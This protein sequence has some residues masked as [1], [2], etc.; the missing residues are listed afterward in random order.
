MFIESTGATVIGSPF[1]STLATPS[2]TVTQD[3][4]TLP[5]LNLGTGA[6]S[7]S[8]GAEVASASCTAGVSVSATLNGNTL[9]YTAASQ[10]YVT[11]VGQSVTVGAGT[12]VSFSDCTAQLLSGQTVDFGSTLKATSAS[13]VTIRLSGGGVLYI[14]DGDILFSGETTVTFSENAYA[15]RV[16]AGAAYN[17]ATGG[18]AVS[19]GQTIAVVGPVTGA[20]ISTYVPGVDVIVL[21]SGRIV[22]ASTGQLVA[23]ILPDGGVIVV[24]PLPPIPDSCRSGA[25]VVLPARGGYSRAVEACTTFDGTPVDVTAAN[26]GAVTDLVVACGG[27]GKHAF[28][29]GWQGI[30]YGA[31]V[32]LAVWSGSTAG[33]GA[34][35]VARDCVKSTPIVCDVGGG[36]V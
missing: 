4:S 9:A 25:L 14:N 27:L 28:I 2:V 11:G 31:G 24:P 22:S 26:V 36:G 3:G 1:V 8:T 33:S 35:A 10:L 7:L 6:V 29:G 21:P 5:T 17:A 13:T 18:V 23:R 34:V 12:V 19:A 15:V 30:D 20:V 16:G 32:C